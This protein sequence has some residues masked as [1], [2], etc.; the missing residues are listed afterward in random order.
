MPDADLTVWEAGNQFFAM[1]RVIGDFQALNPG[2]SVALITLPPGLILKAIRAHGWRLGDDTLT[3]QPDIFATVSIAQLRDTGE[4]TKYLI[5][6]HNALELM[7][8]RGNPDHVTD[9]QDLTRPDLR[10]MLPNPENEGIMSFYAKPILV[11]MGLWTALSANGDCAGCYGA[12]N[13]QFA[14]VHHREIPD[15]IAKGKIDVG[16]VWRTETRAAMAA[17][18]QVEGITL[19]PQQNATDQVSYMAGALDNSPHASAAAAYLRFLAASPGQTAY[20]AYGFI[21][22]SAAERTISMIPKP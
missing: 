15:G 16:L 8:A 4:I 3:Q 7:V 6:M 20:T 10:I 12:P 18:V 22:A 2:L 21:P 1:T 11:Q 13:V 9:L 17:G 5:Y 14:H 19:P